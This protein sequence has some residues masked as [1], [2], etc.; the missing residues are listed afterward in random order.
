MASSMERIAGSSSYSTSTAA[1]PSRAA[2]SVSPTTMPMTWPTQVTSLSAKHSSSCA[3]APMWLSPG[4]SP[5]PKKRT[6]P[7]MASAGPGSTLS[8]LACALVDLTSAPKSSPGSLGRSSMYCAS[9]AVC[10]SAAM[11]MAGAPMTMSA[12]SGVRFQY[13]APLEA[14]RWYTAAADSYSGGTAWEKAPL[15]S[16]SALSE[17]PTKNLKRKEL[18]SEERYSPIPPGTCG[19]SFTCS[20]HAASAAWKVELSHLLPRSA[21][22]TLSATMVKGATPPKETPQ[23]FTVH[24]VGSSATRMPPLTIAM[25]SSRRWDCL[26]SWTYSYSLVK[27]MNTRTSTSPA[28]IATLRYPMKNSRADTRRSLLPA[29]CTMKT[30][31]QATWRGLRSEMGE[32]VQM[33]PPM[34]ETLRIWWPANQWSC[35]RMAFMGRV[36]CAGREAICSANTSMMV[37]RVTLAPMEMP[38]PVTSTLLSSGTWVPATR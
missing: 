26:N 3:M 6:T 33:L 32:A 16:S 11:C 24:V 31:P 35:S 12:F 23:S 28:S 36:W 2:A 17:Q 4:T 9:P 18:V 38:S 15:E 21:F 30:E 27:G 25:S 13:C 14:G 1:A 22:S 29:A 37:V 5:W 10:R 34:P 8:S 20:L 7:L 19:A